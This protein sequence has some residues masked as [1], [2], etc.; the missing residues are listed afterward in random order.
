MASKSQGRKEM[1]RRTGIEKA[2][3][4]ASWTLR[5]IFNANRVDCW[6]IGIGGDAKKVTRIGYL[7]YN[8]PRLWGADWYKLSVPVIC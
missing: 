5:V 8:L 3:L 7:L 6:Y 2:K 1:K 4:I